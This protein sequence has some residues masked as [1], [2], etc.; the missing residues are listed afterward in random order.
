MIANTA[1]L[2]LPA[3][4]DVP[5]L[6]VSSA[7]SHDMQ[8]VLAGLLLD[9][10]TV[11]SATGTALGTVVYGCSPFITAVSLQHLCESFR[12]TTSVVLQ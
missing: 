8:M 9:T 11:I 12:E 1:W 2:K 3:A 6:K 4:A 7:T 5:F 10:T